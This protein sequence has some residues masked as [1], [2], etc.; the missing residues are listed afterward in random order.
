MHSTTKNPPKIQEKK[1]SKQKFKSEQNPQFRISRKQIKLLIKNNSYSQKLNWQSELHLRKKRNKPHLQ[2]L[3]RAGAVKGLG[4]LS[5]DPPL[6]GT[7]VGAAV[8][9]V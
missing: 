1:N 6:A 9:G 4:R 5:S 8:S 2:M 7:R 3:P